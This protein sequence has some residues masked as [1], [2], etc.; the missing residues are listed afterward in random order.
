VSKNTD[1]ASGYEY[2]IPITP[3]GEK[4]IFD[5]ELSTEYVEELRENLIQ[6]G[7]VYKDTT[8]E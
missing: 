1:Y 5:V 2:S 6:V 7:I 3:W 4:G 8:N